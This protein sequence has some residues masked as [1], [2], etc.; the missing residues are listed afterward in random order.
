MKIKS[1]TFELSDEEVD[2]PKI[3]FHKA[4]IPDNTLSEDDM[5]G[6]IMNKYAGPPPDQEE[7]Q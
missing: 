3:S 2:N 4:G 6:Y 7:P 5:V 1:I